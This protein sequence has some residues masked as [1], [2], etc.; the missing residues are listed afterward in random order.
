MW[1]GRTAIAKG[2]MLT[3]LAQRGYTVYSGSV[4][5]RVNDPDA[6]PDGR[7]EREI[8]NK[9]PHWTAIPLRSIAAGE[10]GR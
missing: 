9:A 8:A 4:D 6:D 3:K 10:L 1:D 7:K 5:Y 2:C